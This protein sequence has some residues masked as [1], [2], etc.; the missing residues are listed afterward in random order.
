MEVIEGAVQS[1]SRKGNSIKVND[2]WYS[3]FDASDLDHVQWKDVVEFKWEAKGKYRNIKGAVRK[4][5]SGGSSGGGSKAS[6][7]PWSN[8]GVEIGHASNLAM[9]MMEQL[10]NDGE[11]GHPEIGTAEYFRMFTMHTVN[12]YKVMKAIRSKVE[13]ADGDA[14]A[15]AK[16]AEAAEEVKKEDKSED[17]DFV[18]IEDLF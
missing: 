10:Q 8:V 5:S 17:P 9:R 18:D 7:K 13:A 14:P 12:V 15:T 16:V 2:E 11:G 1:K 3:T 4:V 6:A